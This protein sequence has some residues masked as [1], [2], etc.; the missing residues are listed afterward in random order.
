VRPIEV[1]LELPDGARVVT[2]KE[3]EDAEQLQGRVERR[4]VM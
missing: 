4:A 1:S 2:G 3:R